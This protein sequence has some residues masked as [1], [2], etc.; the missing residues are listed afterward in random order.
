MAPSNEV[1]IQ[2]G[3]E[4]HNFLEK[5]CIDFDELSIKQGQSTHP[6][7]FW[8]LVTETPNLREIALR[9]FRMPSS[10]SGGIISI[11]VITSH[12]LR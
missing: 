4:L 9:I 7:L 8:S 11:I 6:L 10:A 3:K 5:K 2:L 1:L 12:F